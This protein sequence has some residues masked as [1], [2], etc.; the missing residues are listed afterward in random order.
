[1]NPKLISESK[2]ISIGE[3]QFKLLERLS[4]ACGISG[5][6][7]DVRKIILDE[8]RIL[9][10]NVLVDA[11][12]NVIVNRAGKGKNRLKI[13]LAA[14][15]DEV[16]FMVTVDDGGGLFQFRKVGSIDTRQLPG[17]PV[18]IGHDQIPAVIGARAIHL[19]TK[20]Q[21]RSVI[22]L[23]T[24][25]LDI[26]PGESK[27]KVKIGDRAAFSTR[28]C[29]D[30][31]TVRGKALDNRLGVATLIEILKNPPGNVDIQ[32]VFTVQ[33]EIGG[34][35]ASTAAYRL[36]PDLAIILDSTPAYDMPTW[37]DTENSR[38]NTR[39]GL[40]P[41]IYVM[42]PGTISDT[43]L[44]KHFISTAEKQGIPYQIRQPGGGGTDAGSIQRQRE[45]IPSISISVPGRHAHTPIGLAYDSDWLNTL[46]LFNAALRNI[47]P[48]LME[49]SSFI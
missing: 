18:L 44:V 5:D 43:R 39:L 26:G 41:A 9:A 28:F 3:D 34:R 29:H 23:E 48:S 13:M 35:G 49:R 36:S 15:M 19:T 40:G 10:E 17:K 21:L 27:G 22:P 2:T 30:H 31:G 1:M 7:G 11:L 14:H 33:E 38:Y 25:R 46:K 8:V 4:N 47:T 16:G 37:D 12:G 24:L 32:A 42:D 20:E 6:E 45:G